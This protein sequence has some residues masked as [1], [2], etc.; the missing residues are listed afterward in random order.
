MYSVYDR[1]ISHERA[2]DLREKIQPRDSSARAT[3][4]DDPRADRR[5]DK[6]EPYHEDICIY[7]GW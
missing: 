3:S 5:D 4:P 6:S 1:R 7:H 2:E